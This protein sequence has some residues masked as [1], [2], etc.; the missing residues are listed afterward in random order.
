MGGKGKL[1]LPKKVRKTASWAN[2]QP[3][4]R[5]GEIERQKV[6]KAIE[7]RGRLWLIKSWPCSVSVWAN[8]QSV[9]PQ[10]IRPVC[11]YYVNT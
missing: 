10:K 9:P 7:A 8:I 2:F 6:S 5:G 4:I 3:K 11:E 1:P